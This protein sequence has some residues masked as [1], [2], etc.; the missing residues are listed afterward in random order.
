MQTERMQSSSRQPKVYAGESQTLRSGLQRKCPVL[1]L[2][3]TTEQPLQTTMCRLC[4]RHLPQES[5]RTM[6]QQW[7]QL[8]P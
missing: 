2:Q 6:R 7:H 4:N 5:L 8:L 3:R 1:R